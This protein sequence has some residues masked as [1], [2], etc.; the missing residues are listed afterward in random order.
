MT[1]IA[2]SFGTDAVRLN[3]YLKSKGVQYK[4]DSIWV[5]YQKYENCGYTQTKTYAASGSPTCWMI[6][7]V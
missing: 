6:M 3:A 7:V 5:L 4:Q 1:T 2:K